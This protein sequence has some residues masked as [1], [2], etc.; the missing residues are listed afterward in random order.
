MMKTIKVGEKYIGDSMPCFIVAEIG[1]NHCGDI[2]L[3]KQMI[4][5]AAHRG[6]DAVKFQ[7]NNAAGLLLPDCEYYDEIKQSEMSFEEHLE[8]KKCA[9]ECGVI[10]FST[11]D[12][13]EGV[14][15]LEQVGVPMYKV[16]SQDLNNIP[17]LECIASKRKPMIIST[18]MASM[19]EICIS[20]EALHKLATVPDVVLLHCTSKYPTQPSE[21]NL[22]FMHNMKSY[23][24]HQIPVGFSD[25]TIGN[26]VA[27]AAVTMGACLIEKH[28][29]IDK[30]LPGADNAMSINPN[31]FLQLVDDIRDVEA[32]LK[33]T[34]QF[35]ERPDLKEAAMYRRSI[36]TA[37]FIKKG[38]I[39]T[40]DMLKIVRPGN[41]IAPVHLKKIVG[42]KAGRRIPP[43]TQ[44]TWDMVS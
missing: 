5:S 28:F 42:K 16:A 22:A 29:T 1:F 4:R 27:I 31:E 26:A 10:F 23:F 9:D 25:H 6:A 18:G 44:F 14:N 41:G 13:S 35:S 7:T 32:A 15:M 20:M 37:K 12:C 43:N 2:D 24:L 17:L 34:P 21:A 8:L 36:H 30:T 33:Q 40:T 11:P 19:H 3:A 38:M 39:I